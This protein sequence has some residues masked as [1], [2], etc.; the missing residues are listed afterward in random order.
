MPKHTFL[1]FPVGFYIPIIFSN[2]NY[3]YSNVLD[4]RN[5]HGQV[6][7][8]SVSKTVLTLNFKLFK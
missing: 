6:K 1:T 3:N 4:L 8:H 7:K 2:L 5:F